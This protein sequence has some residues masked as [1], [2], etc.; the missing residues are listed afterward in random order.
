MH[1][2]TNTTNAHIIGIQSKTSIK[3]Q[4]WFDCGRLVFPKMFLN[5]Y[6][7]CFH[8]D[9]DPYILI[10][11]VTADKSK[12]DSLFFVNHK[13]DNMCKNKPSQ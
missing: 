3:Y 10:I 2:P 6:N 13:I 9:N 5:C 12:I 7:D 11:E 8:I 1:S 4:M